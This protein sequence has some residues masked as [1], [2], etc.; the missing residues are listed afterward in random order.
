M[1][2][3]T[4]PTTPEFCSG[5]GSYHS[6]F[7][8]TN[9]NPYVTIT[10]EKIEKLI[11]D[12]PCVSK[13]NC[14][15]AIF[16]TKLSRELKIQRS[17]GVFYALWADIDEHTTEDRLLEFL[18]SLQCDYLYYSTKSSTLEK[19]KWRVILPLL[20]PLQGRFYNGYAKAL[21]DRLDNNFI[22]PD[23]A[24]ER[25]NQLCYLPNS[26]EF[27]KFGINNE[28]GRLDCAKAFPNAV[29]SREKRKPKNEV[30]VCNYSNVIDACNAAYDIPTLLDKYGYI[31]C[32]DSRWLSP[33]STSGNAGV[34]ISEDGMKWLSMHSSDVDNGIGKP[35][36]DSGCF[37]DAF[38]LIK[39]F[40]YSNNHDEAL[41]G[42]REALNIVSPRGLADP[43]EMSEFWHIYRDKNGYPKL[44][45]TVENLECLLSGYGI[46]V[47]YDELLKK[48]I[49]TF[50][51]DSTIDDTIGDNGKM[52][53]L[54][55]LCSLNVLPQTAVD[56]LPALYSK[57]RI[58]PIMNWINSSQWD[59]IDRVS[60]V[61]ESIQSSDTDDY[62]TRVI[63]MWLVQCIAA[64]D[65]AEH[66]PIATAQPKYESVLVLQ[67]AQGKGK[68]DWIKSL[69]PREFSNY[70]KEGTHLDPSDRD[71]C[72][73]AVS[74]WICELGEL[75]SSFRKSDIAQLKAFLSLR[76]DGMRLPYDREWST[77]PRQTSFIGTVNPKKFLQDP[78]GS[79]RFWPLHV[80]NLARLNTDDVQQV[81]AQVWNMYTKG[82]AWWPDEKFSEEL[83]QRHDKHTESSPLEDAIM[84][85]FD[86]ESTEGGIF[87]SKSAIRQELGIGAVR[88]LD[89][90]FDKHGIPRTA[91]TGVWGFKLVK[92]AEVSRSF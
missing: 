18:G 63:T 89:E 23:R 54:R 58:N 27:Y 16:S 92:R 13:S 34:S 51:S 75:D 68:T 7:N 87:F 6:E 43:L 35:G 60:Q 45:N 19:Q 10:L 91:Q 80:T 17:E 71:S 90:I 15:W 21:N 67:G 30:S 31:Q 73:E 39:F 53:R 14:Q 26:G 50:P 77:Y 2:D 65:R 1:T 52:A 62:K 76:T 42:I 8:K 72:K 66:S 88:G 74:C 70:I 12:P 9:P 79:R 46:V 22:T 4:P 20:E 49:V 83:R 36:V 56:Y 78:T 5:I 28:I 11:N 41:K 61:I 86:L 44:L 29:L 57:N 64:L 40:D 69:L 38:D 82:A 25:A 59:G 85:K 37:G 81:W 84:D 24:T 47:K 48:P 33:F 3:L 55:S 32:G